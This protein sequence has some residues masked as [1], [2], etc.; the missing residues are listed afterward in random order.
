MMSSRDRGAQQEERRTPTVASCEMPLQAHGFREQLLEIEPQLS[1]LDP[2]DRRLVR[3]AVGRLAAQW[4]GLHGPSH[5]LLIGEVAIADDR[6]RVDIYSDPVTPD[7]EFWDELVRR[8]TDEPIRGWD[9]D[10]RRASAGVFTTF[11]RSV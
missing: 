3:I 5:K 10:R 11:E 1:D 8:Q 9:L 7:P 6:L 4:I 2:R